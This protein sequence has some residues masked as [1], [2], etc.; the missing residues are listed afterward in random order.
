[1]NATAEP[2]AKSAAMATI[3]QMPEDATFDDIFEALALRSRIAEGLRD[4]DGGRSVPHEEVR[5]RMAKWLT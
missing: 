3:S 5:S 1:M 4:L 2:T